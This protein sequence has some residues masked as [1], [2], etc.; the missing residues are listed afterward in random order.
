[1]YHFNRP[2][3]H[4][5]CGLADQVECRIAFYFT[6]QHQLLLIPAR[7]QANA[8]FGCWGADVEAF[9]IAGYALPDVRQGEYTVAV[10]RGLALA[11]ENGVFGAGKAFDDATF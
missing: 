10:D 8:H 2:D 4:P 9:N 11:A 1:M 6:R 3:I 5:A 7:E